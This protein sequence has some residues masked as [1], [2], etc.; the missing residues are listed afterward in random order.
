MS[1]IDRA[2]AAVTP[3]ETD[4]ER[5]E[6]RQR[7]QSLAEPGDWLDQALDHHLEIEAAFEACKE[8]APGEARVEAMRDLG[9][10]LVAHSIAEEV[11]LYPGL[12][13]E[14]SLAGAAMAYQE[15]S[16]AKVQ[17]AFLEKIDP[18]SQ[19]WLDK[20]GH[21]EGAVKHHVY[22]EESTWFPKLKREASAEDQ[23]HMTER[24]A[25]EFEHY[26]GEEYEDDDTAGG[27]ETGLMFRDP[28]VTQA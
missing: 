16:L 17:M 25:E 28:T 21:I 5:I 2:I 6:A 20:L 23:A 12:A 8:A 7:A 18:M 22:E 14:G 13:E 19:D 10:W 9:T 3:P 27:S 26:I 24:Y 1:I 11:A 15:Q 4:Q